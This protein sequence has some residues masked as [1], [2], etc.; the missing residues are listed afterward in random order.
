MTAKRRIPPKNRRKHE[1]I[2]DYAALLAVLVALLEEARRSSVRVVNTI[3]TATYWEIGRQIVEVEQRGDARARYGDSLIKRLA[4]DLTSRFGR[5]FS[6]RSLE[7]FRAFYLAWE[8]PSTVLT[9]SG[10]KLPDVEPKPSTALTEL[11]SVP[12][13]TPLTQIAGY[14]PLPWSHYIYLL[15]VK[16]PQA[17]TFYETEAFRGGWSV[18]QLRRQI[19]S[20]F[21]ERMALSKNKASVLRKGVQPK[22]IDVVS[23]DETVKDPLVLEFL[24][25]KTSIPKAILRMR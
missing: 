18:R 17:R 3:M 22:P 8:N 9:D 10:P 23:V 6:E 11:R 7:R 16:S 15:S 1:A 13:G 19:D 4:A 5:G 24:G 20:Q 12:P 25:L 14:F 2:A 21:Y